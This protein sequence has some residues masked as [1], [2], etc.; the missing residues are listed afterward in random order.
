MTAYVILKEHPLAPSDPGPEIEFHDDDV[1]NY[2][3]RRDNDESVVPVTA[4]AKM[5]ELDLLRGLLIG[6]ANNLADVL[7]KWH[8]GSVDAFVQKMNSEARALGMDNTSYADAAGLLP[9]SRSTAHDQFL[10]AAAAMADPTFAAIVRQPQAELP[11]VGVIYNTNSALGSGGII[12][13]KTGWTEDAGACLMFAAEWEIEGNPQQIV[14]V[15][16]GQDTLEDATDRSRELIL[17]S[18]VNLGAITLGAR[19]ASVGEIKTDWGIAVP[20]LLAEDAWAITVPGV[21]IDAQV[22]MAE[23]LTAGDIAEGSQIG[24]IRY[25]VGQ[26]ELQVP[27]IAS[28]SVGK[29]DLL[30]RLTRLP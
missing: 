11:D 25:L 29:P 15:V 28:S 10:L 4:G 7:A 27:L 8:A 18:G 1:V 26:Q 16:L 19:G 12:G 3:A 6:S 24:S 2:Q 30:W 13:I 14:G 5:T 22:Q 17:V 20:A 9:D 21:T 23:A